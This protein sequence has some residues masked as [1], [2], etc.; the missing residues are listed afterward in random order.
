VRDK[1]S[2]P[3]RYVSANY[4]RIMPLGKYAVAGRVNTTHSVNAITR[5]R[6]RHRDRRSVTSF[7]F[8]SIVVR[9]GYCSGLVVSIA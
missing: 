3:A 7:M 8:I 4:F 6:T 1:G 9:E 5:V 2:E